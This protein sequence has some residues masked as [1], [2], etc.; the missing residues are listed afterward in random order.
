M[1]SWCRGMP[2]LPYGCLAACRS[3]WRLCCRVTRSAAL[4]ISRCCSGQKIPR[5][6]DWRSRRPMQSATRSMRYSRRPIVSS[7]ILLNH[8][9]EAHLDLDQRH[10]ALLRQDVQLQPILDGWVD[11]AGEAEAAL[12]LLEDVLRQVAGD[13]LGDG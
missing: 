8:P 9:A 1:M 12:H 11:V 3:A 2:P 5:D 4:Q 10:R 7:A 13:R 6:I